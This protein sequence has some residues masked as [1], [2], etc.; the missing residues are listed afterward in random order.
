MRFTN[1]AAAR[2]WFRGANMLG[3]M[4]VTYNPTEQLNRGVRVATNLPAGR[5]SRDGPQHTPHDQ[6]CPSADQLASRT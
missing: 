6:R 4:I 3:G 1:P 5:R 2:Q